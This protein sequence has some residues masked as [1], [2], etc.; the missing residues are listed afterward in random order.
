MTKESTKRRKALETLKEQGMLSPALEEE[1]RH[2]MQVEEDMKLEEKNEALSKSRE[3]ES[4]LALINR[5]DL[6]ITKICRWKGCNGP[7]ATNYANVAYCSDRCRRLMLESQG[8]S[9][10]RKKSPEQRWG[11]RGDSQET[12]PA[13]LVVPSETLKAAAHHPVIQ[14]FLSETLLELVA[15]DTSSDVSV[16]SG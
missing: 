10:D 5:Q 8:I 14:Q 13:P 3:A 11:W 7:F 6:F 2:L 1:L 15:A 16:V 12:F 9:W 4:I